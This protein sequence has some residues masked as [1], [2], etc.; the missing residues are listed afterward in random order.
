MPP[1]AKMATPLSLL[2]I[3]VT[4]LYGI[5]ARAPL[6]L[7]GLSS[8]AF[9]DSVPS[10]ILASPTSTRSSVKTN[11][12]FVSTKPTV[13]STSTKF[14]AQTNATV[15]FTRTSTTASTQKAS[16]RSTTSTTTTAAMTSPTPSCP[17]QCECRYSRADCRDKNLREIPDH[18][19]LA[20]TVYLQN[21]KIESL[22][23]AR[24]SKMKMAT[25]IYIRFN[26]ITDI[27]K[28]AFVNM[29]SLRR[30]ALSNNKIA[31][32]SDEAFAGLPKLIILDLENNQISSI[33]NKFRFLSSKFAMLSIILLL[34][35]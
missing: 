13:T 33:S 18:L 26:L 2:I 5:E 35:Q 6:P 8:S 15:L 28:G 22:N 1:Q 25:G 23:P 24:I 19:E 9:K 31:T 17:T 30:L 21:N 12:T 27:P 34:K 16:I 11:K 10:G 3:T 7:V 29:S 14:I 4:F 32:I 20:T